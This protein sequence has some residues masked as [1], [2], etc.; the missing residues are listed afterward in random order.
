MREMWIN[1][2]YKDESEVKE[3]VQEIASVFKLVLSNVLPEVNSKAKYILDE[4]IAQQARKRVGALLDRYPEVRLVFG[5][6]GLGWVPY[7]LE[8]LDHEHHKYASV[9][10]D[11]R[12]PMTPREYF[13][14]QVYGCWFFEETAPQRL[15]DKIGAANI[16]FETDY[17][18]PICLYGRR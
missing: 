4:S 8:R 3:E 1:F 18:H 9:V 10:A 7:V 6:A 11:V 2:W 14:R 13:H 15:V 16:L 5:E 17:P 12:L